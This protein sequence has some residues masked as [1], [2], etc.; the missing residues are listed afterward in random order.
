MNLYI[1]RD[2]HGFD[3][4]GGLGLG[5]GHDNRGNRSLGRDRILDQNDVHLCSNGSL[6]EGDLERGIWGSRFIR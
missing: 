2:S 6:F 5:L 3:I 1:Y 4:H